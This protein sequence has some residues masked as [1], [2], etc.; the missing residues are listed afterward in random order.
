MI[1]SIAV[2]LKN[3]FR[4][5]AG[6]KIEKIKD[7]NRFTYTGLIGTVVNRACN[8]K[9]VKIFSLDVKDDKPV[10]KPD[11]NYMNEPDIRTRFHSCPRRTEVSESPGA[12]MSCGS[13]CVP[14]LYG[15]NHC[16]GDNYYIPAHGSYSSTD[17]VM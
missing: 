6:E 13:C 16:A 8:A 15:L 2:F 17:K 10:L 1:I 12:G 7:R 11:E 9:K 5:Y 14:H 4:I 3:F